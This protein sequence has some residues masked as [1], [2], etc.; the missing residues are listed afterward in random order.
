MGTGSRHLL[1][2]LLAIVLLGIS[3]GQA[4]SE[5]KSG[6]NVTLTLS[7]PANGSFFA[8]GEKATVTLTLKDAAGH[9][10]T[11]DD[12]ETLSLYVFGPQD[13]LKTVTA[14]KL[15]KAST[16]R[17]QETHHYIN[18]LAS[19]SAQF[20]GNFVRFPLQAISDEEP[21]TYTASV[22]VIKKGNPP[23]QQAFFLTDFQ[24]KTATAE[25]QLVAE[26]KCAA[27]HLGAANGQLYLHHVDPGRTAYGSPAIDSQPVRTCK[28]CHNND[29][30]AA[31]PSPDDGKTRIADPILFRAHGVHMGVNLKNP[32]NTDHAKGIFANYADVVFPADAKDCTACHV[33]DRWKTKPSEAACNACHDNIWLGTAENMPK[34]MSLHRPPIKDAKCESCH[35]PDQEGKG[36]TPISL[37]HKIDQPLNQVTVGLTPAKNGKFYVAGEKPVVTLVIKDNSA[38]PV[39]HTKVNPAAFM[40]AALFVYGPT[41]NSKPVLTEAARSGTLKM[42]AS[43]TNFKNAEGAEAKGWTFAEGDT[44]KIAVNNAPA[45]ELKAPVGFQTPEQVKTWLA[46]NLKDVTVRATATAVSIESTLQGPNSR[47]A[48][49]DSP[50]TKIMG[51]KQPGLKL[52]RGG[53]TSGVTVEPYISVPRASYLGN[54]LRGSTDPNLVRKPENITYQLDDVKDLSPGTYMI[55]V[56]VQPAGKR[57]ATDKAADPKFS[58][59]AIGFMTFQVGTEEPDKQVATNCKNCHRET[60]WH[61]DEGPQHPEPFDP[62]YCKA[63]HDYAREAT[64]NGFERLGGSSLN[65]WSGYGAVP[66]SRRVHGVHFGK[67]LN[68]PEEIYAGNPN[69]FTDAIFPQDVRNCVKCHS[70]DTTGTWKTEPSRLAC[71]SCHDS[72]SANAHAMLQTLNRTPDDEWSEGKVE[73]CGLCHGAGKE[74]SVEKVH[75]ISNPYKPPYF[76]EEAK[77]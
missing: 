49:Y 41:R 35:T 51:W 65:G 7:R 70:G 31:Y 19:R 48:I 61:L 63:C 72:K 10:L 22:R 50:V 24:V 8:S 57:L 69:Q 68:F 37:T 76:R 67:Y 29:G 25:K 44:F 16:D 34:G 17:S 32:K 3:T 58:N 28:S 39:D 36:L 26:E 46:A 75:N 43:V 9:D 2:A 59:S 12:L 6:L 42:R 74:F 15:L 33:D 23:A 13:P 66:L 1:F 47:F 71:M 38:K 77:R 53:M 55:Y 60:I 73:T 56:W 11:K 40:T 20:R 27:C 54:D 18:L 5:T 14:A 52:A 64:G 45:V 30:Y 4:V 21:G 62:A